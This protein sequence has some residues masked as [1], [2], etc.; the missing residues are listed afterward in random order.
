MDEDQVTDAA[1]MEVV[2]GGADAALVEGVD[3]G[4]AGEDVDEA[5]HANTP[6]NRKLP[7]VCNITRQT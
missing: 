7:Q 3:E 5:D 6:A 1:S 2:G 4:A